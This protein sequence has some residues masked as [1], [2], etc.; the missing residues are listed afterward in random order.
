MNQNGDLLVSNIGA[1]KS[2]QE[3]QQ[4]II[5]THA[6]KAPEV[7]Q[8]EFTY[9]SDVYS[10]GIF[11]WELWYRKPFPLPTLDRSINIWKDEDLT[12][13]ETLLF[14]QVKSIFASCTSE[15]PASRPSFD[16]LQQLSTF[17]D[18]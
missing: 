5:G 2:V 1:S 3:A 15:N 11:I 12:E 9:K 16:V 10:F 8:K 14:E 6:Y 18:I 13:C 17:S 7:L 4:T